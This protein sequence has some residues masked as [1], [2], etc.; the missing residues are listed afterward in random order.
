MKRAL[1]SVSDKTGIEEFARELVALDFEILSTGGTAEALLKAHIPV[2]E[3]SDVIDFPEFLDGRVK[4]LHP[5]IHGG[6]LANRSDKRH[7][8]QIKHLAIELIDLV[9][10]NLYPFEKTIEKPRVTLKEAI[11]NIDIGGPAMVRGAAKNYEGV[12][13]VIDPNDYESVITHIK[14]NTMSLDYRYSLAV[15]AF[16]HTARYDAVVAEYLREHETNKS[17][18]FPE[19]V[20]LSFKKTTDMR[21]GEN[22]HQHAAFYKDVDTRQEPTS[23]HQLHGKALSYNNIHDAD[24]AFLLSLEFKKPTVVAVKHTNPCGVATGNTI[25]EAFQ[26]AYESDPLSIF[27][28]V[29][30]ANREIDAL[31]ATA[32]N[33]IFIEIVV[34]PSFSEEALD[35]LMVKPNIRLMTYPN[36]NVR[37]LPWNYKRVTGGLLI[38]QPDTQLYQSL[39]PVT[40][41]KP[42]EQELE[43]LLFAWKVSK[44]TKSNAIIIAKN[45][46]TLG[47]GPGQVS[48]VGAVEV[49]IKQAILH[50]GSDA[51]ADASL[52]SDGYFP[53]AD[54]VEVAYKAGITSIIQPGGSIRDNEVIE[55]CDAHGMTMV[56]TGMRHFNH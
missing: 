9:V 12:A 52:A 24:A 41:V 48:R 18:D 42:T 51:L 21:Y 33:D 43:N 19:T 35:I 40:K 46:Q 23:F 38:Q 17:D 26:K 7:M 8:E 2:T 44:H 54:S 49:A 1:I 45:N 30:V 29:I 27:G 31:T 47:I 13:V 34:A 39:T 56:F 22:P 11:E 25:F 36:V 4:T 20:T 3:V 5:K 10:V 37:A 50:F 32:I 6:I 28:G 15:K 53:F 14:D 16:N 55:Y